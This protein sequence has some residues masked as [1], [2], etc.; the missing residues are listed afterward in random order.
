MEFKVKK[1]KNERLDGGELILSHASQGKET[2]LWAA[3]SP[4]LI[5]CPLLQHLECTIPRDHH[6]LTAPDGVQRR[7]KRGRTRDRAGFSPP[8][9]ALKVLEA[10]KRSQRRREAAGGRRLSP[11]PPRSTME[12][13]LHSHNLLPT[14]QRNKAAEKLSALF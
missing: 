12:S 14:A 3:R 5:F 6:P 10:A 1:Q 2:P 11:P 7:I 8:K 4:S 13:R 9:D